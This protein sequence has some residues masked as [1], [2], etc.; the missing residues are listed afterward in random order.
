M[1]KVN[2]L[3][4][5]TLGQKT[6]AH[7]LL[8]AK[9]AYMM[10]RKFEEGDWAEVY[11]KAK[12]IPVKRWSNLNIDIMHEGLGVEHKMLCYRS[13]VDLGEAFGQTMMHPAATRAIRV[14][15]TNV[16]PD[17]AMREIFQQYAALIQQ[18]SEKVRETASAGNHPDMRTGWLLWQE[19][20]CQFL[21]FEEPMLAPDP[22]NFYAKWHDSGGGPRK[23]SRNLWV[24]DKETGHKRYSITTAAGAKIQPYFDVPPPNDPNVYLFTVIGEVIGVGMVRVWLTI[25][26]FRELKRVLGDFDTAKL[27]QFVLRKLEGVSPSLIVR[28]G[29][30]PAAE[31]IILTAEAYS[32][33][34]AVFPGVNDDNSFQLFLEFLAGH[35]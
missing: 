10:G 12:D 7:A 5:F 24:F 31:T 34:K 6:K 4:A 18:R 21:Y 32:R 15:P 1:V 17:K 3:P 23:A 11:C 13:D 35:H 20:L 26:T 8:A 30:E 19:S 2:T 9:V 16:D 22:K 27:S 28:G 14:P 29:D 25:A 33:L